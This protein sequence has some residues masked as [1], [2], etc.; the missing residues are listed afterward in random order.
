MKNNIKG[1]W[2]IL[3]IFG[4]LFLTICLLLLLIFNEGKKSYTVTFDLDGGILISGSLEQRVVQGQDATLPKVAK[5]G[6]YLKGWSASH[7]KITR[8]ITLTAIWE[9]NTTVGIIYA[10]SSN[11]NFTEIVGSYPYLSGEVY[12]GAYFNDKKIL[13]IGEGAFMNRSGITKVYLLNGLISIGESAFAGC[14][15]LTEI[16]IPKTVTHIE[17][18]AFAGCTSLE[19][20]ILN[21]GLKKIEAGAFA[22]CEKL[23]VIIIPESVTEIAEGAFDGCEN[24]V[25]KTKITESN[26]PRG[27][28]D[29]WE[30]DATIDWYEDPTIFDVPEEE[31]TSSDDT[32]DP[33]ESTN[34]EETNDESETDAPE[35]KIGDGGQ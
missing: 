2:K 14:T 13:S 17:A 28:K 27:W 10:N 16:E 25:I 29:G 8:D 9:Y 32:T 23:T 12:L 33:E 4:V 1:K 7:Q 19:V 22:D 11:Q 20:V 30:G 35:A 34:E 18:D 24:L 26:T 3:I 21:E 31:E 15:S 5:D 6:A